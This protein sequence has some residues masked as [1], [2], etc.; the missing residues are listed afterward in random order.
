[1]ELHDQPIAPEKEVNTNGCAANADAAL[2]PVEETAS[3]TAE[4]ELEA[5]ADEMPDEESVAA[6]LVSVEDTEPQP[7]LTK[8][9]IIN[10]LKEIAENDSADITADE[11]G[12]IKQQFYQL[13]NDE[14]RAERDRF[15]AE[16]GEPEAFDPALD[17]LED[18]FKELFGVVKE[19][20]AALRARQDAEREANLRTKREIIAELAS[21]STD[22]D[23][24]NR[25]YN[26]AKE[27]QAQFLTVGEV[28]PTEAS[29]VWKEYQEVRERFYDQLKINKELRDYDFKKN[30]AEK[31]LLCSQAEELNAESDVIVAFRRLQELHDKWREIGPVSKEIREEI[32]TRFKDASAAVNKRYQAYFEERKARELENEQAKTA[33]C[34]RVE[35]LDFASLTTYPAWDDMT[36]TIMEAQAEWKKI[37]FASRKS[38]NALFSR[39]RQTCD[40]FFKAKAEF[41]KEMKD[42]MASNLA[43]K[44]ELCEKA[45]ALKD[46]TDWR[47]TTDAL[48]ALQKEWKTIGHVSKKH[49]DTVWKRFMGACDAFFD[50]KKEV[51]G[52]QRATEQENLKAKQAI[53]DELKSILEGE[54]TD[55]IKAGLRE[56][57]RSMRDKWQ[58]IGHVPFKVK[59]KIYDEFR[60]LQ[61]DVEKKFD[62]REVRARRAEFEAAVADMS[63]NPG[64]LNRERD[65]LVRALEQR[66]SDLATYSNN[67]GFLT[68]KSKSGESMLREMERR[69]ERLREEIVQLE[70]KIKVV[71]ATSSS[72]KA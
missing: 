69:M 47:K 49:S 15:I 22:A 43:R 38:N 18:T 44:I 33:L 37:G 13:K 34:E 62:L 72:D 35:A 41:F 31:Q 25:Q 19:K 26:R 70:E 17:P 59:D 42:T 10:R 63:A 71:D 54:T 24:V 40:N 5:V 14:A 9:T 67:L 21:I 23:N 61:R 48:V 39:F 36:K 68:S 57:M 4:A 64:R 29:A 65:R 2:N 46:S 53:I 28:P 58:E 52:S 50:H 7:G 20:K 60:Q 30:L 56:R 12:R 3:A 6:D 8:E 1:M 11:L 51:T 27:L 45:E 55:E 66:R 32:W 16:G